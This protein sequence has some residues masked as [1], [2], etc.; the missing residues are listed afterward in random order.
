MPG[1]PSCWDYKVGLAKS[2]S[3]S[4]NKD[5]V[6]YRLWKPLTLPL[7]NNR[8]TCKAFFRQLALFHGTESKEVFTDKTKQKPANSER[9]LKLQWLKSIQ[10]RM[11]NES[12]VFLAGVLPCSLTAAFSLNIQHTPPEHFLSDH[13]PLMNAL[14]SSL[15]Q[16]RGHCMLRSVACDVLNEFQHSILRMS[17]VFLY[18]V[19]MWS[20]VLINHYKIKTWFNH[21]KCF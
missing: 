11:C 1:P 7:G 13:T 17:L 15:S 21:E 10:N 14:C 4:C 8:T 9:S 5:N 2:A 3:N 16:S 18:S 12:E 19:F 6:A 20:S